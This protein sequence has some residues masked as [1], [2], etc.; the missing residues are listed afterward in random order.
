MKLNEEWKINENEYECP[1]CHK[2]FTKSGI[3]SHIICVH[4]KEGRERVERNKKLHS[5][6]QKGHVAWNKGLTKETDE[7]IKKASETY[8]S[9]NYTA[10]NKGK[11][12]VFSEETLKIISSKMKEIAKHRVSC[13]GTGRAYKGWYKGYWCDSQWELA[14]VIYNLDHKI[15]IRRCEEFFEYEYQNEIHLYYPDFITNELEYNEIKGYE[16]E[17]DRAKFKAFPKDK[18]LNIYKYKQLKPIFDYVIREYNLKEMNDIHILYDEQ[19][20]LDKIKEKKNEIKTIKQLEFEKLKNEKINRI[21]SYTNIDFSKQGW[22]TKVAKLEN[23]SHSSVKRFMEKYM[24]DFYVT[25]HKR[26]NM[27]PSFNG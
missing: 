21:L 10:W 11:K 13:K 8:K 18:I 25:C 5:K 20:K 22:V 15:P 26:K 7:R 12:N 3:C 2:I 16:S 19:Y 6:R 23:I 27:R 9:K 1:E 4:T 17:K 24:K 14:F